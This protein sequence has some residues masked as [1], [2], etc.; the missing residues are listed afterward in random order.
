MKFNDLYI[1]I[2][3]PPYQKIHCKYSYQHYN[4][5]L[6]FVEFAYISNDVPQSIQFEEILGTKEED[7]G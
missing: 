5:L 4:S 6:T 7:Q 1:N 2:Q 3:T